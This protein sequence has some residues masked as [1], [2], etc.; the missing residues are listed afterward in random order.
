VVVERERHESC[1]FAHLEQEDGVGPGPYALRVR[2]HRSFFASS[3]TFATGAF[4]R[5]STL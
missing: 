4:V 5:F 1:P 2:F 3:I